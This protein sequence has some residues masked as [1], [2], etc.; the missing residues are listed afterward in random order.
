MGARP[1][2]RCRARRPALRPPFPSPGVSATNPLM[3]NIASKALGAA[4]QN[5][6]AL[7]RGFAALGYPKCLAIMIASAVLSVLLAIGLWYLLH[8]AIFDWRF[9][10]WAWVNWLLR[11]FGAVG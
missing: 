4:A 7:A 11:Q 6:G 5:S 1:A 9:F 10:N 2:I 3:A 8:W